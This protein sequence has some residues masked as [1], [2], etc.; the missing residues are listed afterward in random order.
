MAYDWPYQVTDRHHPITWRWTNGQWWKGT[1]THRQ[2]GG[3][4]RIHHLLGLAVIVGGLTV[5]LGPGNNLYFVNTNPAKYVVAA[6]QGNDVVKYDSV[7]NAVICLGDGDDAA[8]AQTNPANGSISVMGGPGGDN[9]IGTSFA[10]GLNGGDG[11]D[12]I[13]ASLGDDTIKGGAGDDQI[14][15]GPGN[16]TGDA[17]PGFDTCVGTENVIN[18]EAFN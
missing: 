3:I 17:G 13:S 4:M 15:G 14:F 8:D 6:Q 11:P 12:F 18:C 7:S 10:D 1:T 2:K 5:P 16:D 9:I